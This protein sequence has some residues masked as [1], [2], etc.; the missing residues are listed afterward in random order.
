F[1][2][3]KAAL[4]ARSTGRLSIEAAVLHGFGDVGGA[5][6]SA[7]RE[8]RDRAGDLE[9]AVVRARAQAKASHCLIDQ[10]AGRVVEAAHLLHLLV[11]EH[12]VRYPRARVLA[13]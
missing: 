9:D 11:A 1:L 3:A 2:F 8:I 12:A 10:G 4:P 7:A 6:G 13:G 5:H